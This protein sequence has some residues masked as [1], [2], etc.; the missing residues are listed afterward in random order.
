MRSS[1]LDL[2]STLAVSDWTLLRLGSF[3]ERDIHSMDNLARA[4][5]YEVEGHGGSPDFVDHKAVITA[6]APLQ[7]FVDSLLER[8]QA[9]TTYTIHYIVKHAI[10]LAE[11]L[12][13]MVMTV[14]IQQRN[15]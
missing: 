1:S 7:V 4:G 10:F 6:V 9:H 11:M 14:E 12:H 15:L 8:M 13:G 5:S 3:P 2:L